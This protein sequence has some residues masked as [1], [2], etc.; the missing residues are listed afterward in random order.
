MCEFYPIMVLLEMWGYKLKNHCVVFMTDNAA[1]VSILND[2]TCKCKRVMKM[3][4]QF[5][6]TSMKFNVLFKAQHIP[7]KL[8]VIADCL[9]RSKY[10]EEKKWAP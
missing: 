1:L 6:L 8:N 10:Q 4:R 5:V 7:G 3:L 9:S 2:Q